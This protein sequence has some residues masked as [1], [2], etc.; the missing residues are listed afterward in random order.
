VNGRRPGTVRIISGAKRGRQLAVPRTGEVRPT[1]E[2]VRE[3]IFD[4]LG[5]IGGLRVVDL[6]AGT[7]ALGLEALSR[8]AGACVFVDSDRA[9][10]AL[11][12]RNIAAL[13]YDA[14]CRVVVA[15][16]RKALARLGD[17]SDGFDL[18]FVDPPYRML[19]DVEV[20]LTPLLPGLLSPGGVVVIEGPRSNRAA[21][22][23]ALIF[24]RAYGDTSVTMVKLR[25]SDP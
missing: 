9:V 12:Q 21:F 5:P 2:M 11:L 7:G 17:N 23:Q 10:A 6:F 13:G 19:P 16:Y 3:A 14:I 22:G 15:D 1:S 8:G 4:V 18:L 20:A 25:R 24:E